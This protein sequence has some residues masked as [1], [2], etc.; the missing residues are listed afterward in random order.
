MATKKKNKKNELS[1]SVWADAPQDAAD[2]LELASFGVPSGALTREVLAVGNELLAAMPEQPS[3]AQSSAAAYVRKACELTARALTHREALRSMSLGGG[4]DH[5]RLVAAVGG[6]KTVLQAVAQGPVVELASEGRAVEQAL[7][8]VDL[9]AARQPTRALLTVVEAAQVKLAADPALRAR[10]RKLVPE[11]LVTQL[12]DT[13]EAVRRKPRVGP[14]TGDGVVLP[15]TVLRAQLLRA[16][17]HY[18]AVCLAAVAPDAAPVEVARLNELLE[19]LTSL[20]SDVTR[21][22]QVRAR[23]GAVAEVPEASEPTP[24]A[25]EALEPPEPAEEVDD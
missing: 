11:E 24:E 25:L 20:R 9:D 13:C 7:F 5:N 2:T 12:L 23:R 22:R 15:T 4:Q 3:A 18:V 1:K 16:I 10:V 21:R 17:A 14:V 6:V 19:P 8:G